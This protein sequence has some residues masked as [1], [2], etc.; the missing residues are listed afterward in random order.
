MPKSK[1]LFLGRFEG[2]WGH[3]SMRKTSEMITVSRMQN[4]VEIHKKN[5]YFV[6]KSLFKK[7]KSSFGALG[8]ESPPRWGHVKAFQLANALSKRA[9]NFPSA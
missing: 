9:V 5:T 2:L 3:G 6:T 7:L 1:S 8:V 4:M